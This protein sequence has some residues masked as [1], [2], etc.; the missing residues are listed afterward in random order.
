VVGGIVNPDE[1]YVFKPTLEQGKEAVVSK[2]MGS[3]LVKMVYSK[4]GGSEI[5]DTTEEE[6]NTWASTPEEVTELAKIAMK[7]EKHYGR[8]MDIEW[9]KD[10]DDGKLYIVQARPE[11]VASRQS[12]NVLET[13]SMDEKGKVIA[14]GR[15]VGGRIGSG[16]VNMLKSLD[17]MSSFKAGDVLVADMTDPD[18]EPVMSKASAIITNRGGRTCHA[19]IIAR[20]LGIPAIVGSGNATEL[21]SNGQS[22]TVSCAEGD[23]G[24][25]YDGELKFT[26][27]VKDLGKL[28]EIGFKIMMNVGNPSAAFEFGQIP[29]EG[30]GLARLEFVINNAGWPTAAGSAQL[31]Q[32]RCRDQGSH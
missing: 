16:K 22:V 20:E 19:A 11:T 3:K 24:F 4:G 1:F 13:Y 7:I 10:A 6:R 18:W 21:V 2:T 29:N 5:I 17:D 31:R 23:T 25:I 26:K 12:K 27:D 28:P 9:C 14:E 15:A 8:P 32:H 30:I